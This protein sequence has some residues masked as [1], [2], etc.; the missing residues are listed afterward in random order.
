[1]KQSTTTLALVFTL[2]LAAPA[3][4]QEKPDIPKEHRPPPG[5]CRIWL[6]SVPSGQQPATTDCATALKN[7]PRNGRVIFGDDY[8]K[9][10]K[11]KP[12]IKGFTDDKKDSQGREPDS[13]TPDTKTRRPL[14]PPPR[15]P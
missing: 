13:V 6:D 5:M 12:P 11:K 4:A 10:D 15:R 14:L 1:M 9:S 7:R 2:A 3:A 8:A